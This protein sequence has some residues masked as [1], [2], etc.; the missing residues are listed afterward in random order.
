MTIEILAMGSHPVGLQADRG[1]DRL[2]FETRD[3]TLLALKLGG[4]LKTTEMGLLLKRRR[5]SK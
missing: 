4:T 2:M 5:D 1:G 3:Y